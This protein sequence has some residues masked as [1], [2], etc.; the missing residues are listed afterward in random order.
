M[1]TITSTNEL[2]RYEREIFKHYAKHNC[3]VDEMIEDMK[4]FT[5]SWIPEGR[6]MSTVKSA[7][8]KLAA[9]IE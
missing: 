6:I 1:E 5:G 2:T 8:R 4:L 7:I 3:S 9:S